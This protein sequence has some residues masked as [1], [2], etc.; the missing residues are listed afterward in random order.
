[1]RAR[2]N[3]KSRRTLCGISKAKLLHIILSYLQLT[4][5]RIEYQFLDILMKLDQFQISRTQKFL[6]I[7]MYNPM[8]R[9]SA[10]LNIFCENTRIYVKWK[11][12]F[13]TEVELFHF[14]ELPEIYL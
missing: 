2:G 10:P 8:S 1:M 5:C 12:I 7:L 13:V 11:R 6:R 4:L 14:E 9:T 3:G